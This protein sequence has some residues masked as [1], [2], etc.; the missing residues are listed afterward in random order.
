MI[1][2]TICQPEAIC[3]HPKVTVVSVAKLLAQVIWR[4][5]AGESIS[6]LIEKT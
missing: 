6:N 5:H 3:N 1:S 2:D 4:I